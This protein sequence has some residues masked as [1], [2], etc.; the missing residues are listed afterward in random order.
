M[1]VP[2]LSFPRPKRPRRGRPPP[3][4]QQQFP[5]PVSSL[6]E[7]KADN[8]L[9]RW[10]RGSMAEDGGGVSVE[11]DGAML[12]KMGFFGERVVEGE[13]EDFGR[14]NKGLVRVESFDP[15][16]LTLEEDPQDKSEEETD[17]KEESESDEDST[18]RATLTEK[19]SSS[20]EAGCGATPLRGKGCRDRAATKEAPVKRRRRDLESTE[21]DCSVRLGPLEAH[22]L[23]YA[24][25]CLI[26]TDHGGEKELSLDE[27]WANYCS[28][29][30][31]FPYRYVAYH[32]FRS[33]GWVVRR[34]DKFG[35]DLLLYKQ[36]P[37]FYHASYSVRVI[38]PEEEEKVGWKDLQGLNRVTESAAKELLL[39]R[40]RPPRGK[41]LADLV[42]DPDLVRRSSVTETLVRRWV[43]EQMRE[44]ED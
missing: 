5:V 16:P 23:G 13:G 30:V 3:V 9:W 17:A 4:L 21:G 37:P 18:A 34:G 24:L 20:K 10:Y 15:T 11:E 31:R 12:L 25:G 1:F 39:A 33:K 36:G 6:T 32:H 35:A 19:S 7:L 8:A 27:T 40:V 41:S 2:A 22:F 44:E 38:G 42:K 28:Q 14:T 26:T 43:P 29:D